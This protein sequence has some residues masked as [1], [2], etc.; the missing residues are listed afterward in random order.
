VL[1]ARRLSSGIICVSSTGFILPE[2]QLLDRIADLVKTASLC[3][4]ATVGDHQPH[5]SLMAYLPNDACDEIYMLTGKDSHKYRNLQ[6]N[7]SVSLL[8]DN[9]GEDSREQTVALTVNGRYDPK[10]APQKRR[11]ELQRLLTAYPHLKGLADGSDMEL[12]CIRVHS[13]LFLKGPTESHFIEL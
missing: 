3:V 6:Q 1:S 12:I 9:R 5:C 7:R 8:I 11:K 10:I 4:F 13:F 2:S